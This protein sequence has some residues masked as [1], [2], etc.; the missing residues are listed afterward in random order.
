MKY[1]KTIAL[2]LA[3]ITM[4]TACKDDDETTTENLE[5]EVTE[6][7]QRK[8]QERESLATLL[9]TLTGQTVSPMNDI[10]F[11]GQTYEPVYGEVADEA[12]PLCRTV[13]VRSAAEA[14]AA[15][16]MLV[17]GND[18]LVAETADGYVIDMTALDC[19][20][21]GKRQNLGT[22]TF[23][24]EDG[25]NDMGYA[26]VS[27]SCMPHLQQID[28]KTREQIGKNGSFTSPCGYGDVFVN[29]GKYYICVK[30]SEGYTA[31]AAGKLVAME[32]GRGTNWRLVADYEDDLRGLW[33]PETVGTAYDITLFL[34]LC[35]DED[36][37]PQKKRITKKYPGQV[38]PYACQYRNGLSLSPT[39][40]SAADEGFGTTMRGYSHYVD[41]GIDS[42]NDLGSGILVARDASIGSYVG[43]FQGWWR[44]LHFV[45]FGPRTLRDKDVREHTYSFSKSQLT[46]F[47]NFLAGFDAIYTCTV[48]SFNEKKPDGFSL[49]DI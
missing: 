5:E 22:L 40:T 27:I 2:L 45:K 44:M 1:L 32:A 38:F 9:T 28:Y 35:A 39:I 48:V 47:N 43:L 23:H 36:F 42:S 3:V 33:L 17:G 46:Q 18:D 29:K 12:Q 26:E 10:D 30:E 13:C 31:N 11:E 34:L 21:T 7:A 16:L 49:V 8:I 4:A 15:F 41:W 19:H 24:R 6:E 14:E 20:S 25:R 37:L